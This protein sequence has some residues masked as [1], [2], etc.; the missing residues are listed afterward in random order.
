MF[1]RGGLPPYQNTPVIACSH[2]LRPLIGCRS[3]DAFLSCTFDRSW[4]GT[5]RMSAGICWSSWYWLVCTG[6][7]RDRWVCLVQP[8]SRLPSLCLVTIQMHSY[9]KSTGSAGTSQLLVHGYCCLFRRSQSNNSLPLGGLAEKLAFDLH[10]QPLSGV[11][12][13]VGR[14][15]RS[16]HCQNRI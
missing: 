5:G 1:W 10:S 14:R 8:V 16:P 15:K 4:T 2:W 7:E 11:F 6:L 12:W 9:W 13:W 3:A